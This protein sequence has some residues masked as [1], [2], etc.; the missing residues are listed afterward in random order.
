[1][2]QTVGQQLNLNMLR[3]QEMPLIPRGGYV[4]P[5]QISIR[6]GPPKK[7][8]PI[9]NNRSHHPLKY[10]SDEERKEARSLRTQDANARRAKKL[11]DGRSEVTKLDA[12]RILGM[13]N[14]NSARHML[15]RLERMNLVTESGRYIN[16]MQV[17]IPYDP[18]YVM[19]PVKTVKSVSQSIKDGFGVAREKYNE[20]MRLAGIEA[21][22]MRCKKCF[23]KDDVL[24]TNDVAAREQ[25]NRPV[26]LTLVKQWREKGLITQEGVLDK[27]MK[28]W[29]I[30]R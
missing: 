11:F 19:P 10:N 17:F 27:G 30:V 29:R 5:Q 4:A 15:K 16:G 24:S 28:T 3:Y 2:R 8:A 1:M 18:N 13:K 22:R 14:D 7:R 21:S 12:M 20:R 25:L 6:Q 26:A 23:G 9:T